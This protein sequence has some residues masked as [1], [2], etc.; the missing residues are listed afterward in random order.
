V[1]KRPH[2]SD[3]RQPILKINGSQPASDSGDLNLI[4]QAPAKPQRRRNRREVPAE[5]AGERLI[6]ADEWA[7]ACGVSKRQFFRW[8]EQGHVP[9]P[10]LSIGQVRRWRLSTMRSWMESNA[11]GRQR[12]VS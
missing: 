9:L 2:N 12:R 4:E 1:L 6:S 10:D 3:D 5:M 11:T 8:Q 7:A